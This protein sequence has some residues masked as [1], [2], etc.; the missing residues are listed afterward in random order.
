MG[1]QLKTH[2]ISHI[3]IVLGLAE[4]EEQNKAVWSHGKH[5][6]PD[7]GRHCQPR[8]EVLDAVL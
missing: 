6:E 8:D 1:M 5:L 3:K 7:V 4:V 2:L